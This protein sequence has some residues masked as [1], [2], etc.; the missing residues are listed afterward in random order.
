[1]EEYA[2][3]L[4]RLYQR[5]Y[6]CS[7]RGSADVERMGQTVL[8]HQFAAGLKPEIRVKVAGHELSSC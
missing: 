2:Q 6:L 1:M 5:A 4:N 3:D 7:E 8:A